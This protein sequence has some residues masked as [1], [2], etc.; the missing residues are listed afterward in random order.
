MQ[1]P[2]SLSSLIERE[3]FM[4]KP[5]DTP[6]GWIWGYDLAFHSYSFVWLVHKYAVVFN[7]LIS[8]F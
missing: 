6:D 2:K 3:G 5:Q 8:S 1:R 4:V 7:L